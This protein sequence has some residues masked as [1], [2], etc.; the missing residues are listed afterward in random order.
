MLPR[1]NE[2]R[3]TAKLGIDY[4]V[5]QVRSAIIITKIDGGGLE[6]WRTRIVRCSQLG[7]GAIKDVITEIR[8]LTSKRS[9]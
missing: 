5:I 9:Q 6:L 4:P 3:L 1:W 2:N 8:S 7:A